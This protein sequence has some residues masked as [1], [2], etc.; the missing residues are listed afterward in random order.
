MYDYI[1]ILFVHSVTVGIGL[2]I[3]HVVISIV[4]RSAAVLSTLLK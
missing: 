2:F 4:L 3:A 1:I